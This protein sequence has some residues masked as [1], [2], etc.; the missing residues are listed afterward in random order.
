MLTPVNCWDRFS[1]L[2]EPLRLLFGFSSQSHGGFKAKESRDFDCGF[3][4]GTARAGAFSPSVAGW[5]VNSEIFFEPIL[6]AQA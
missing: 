5:P 2:N 3:G 4:K 1:D 6:E